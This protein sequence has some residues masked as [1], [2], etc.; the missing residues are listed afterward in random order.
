MPLN[1]PNQEQFSSE[2]IRP[3]NETVTGTNTP[4]Q[5]G[6]NI[7]EQVFHT[8]QTSRTGASLPGA[9]ESYIQKKNLIHHHRI[10]SVYS[11]YR[12]QRESPLKIHTILKG[13][14]CCQIY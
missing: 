6:T 3:T 10:Q 7:N 4:G 11:G 2:S 14:Y 13:F 9:F 1:K 12:R 5:T 8:L